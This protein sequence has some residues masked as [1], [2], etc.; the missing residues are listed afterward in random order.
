MSS[1]EKISVQAI[2]DIMRI[3]PSEELGRQL[4]HWWIKQESRVAFRRTIQPNNRPD[5]PETVYQ[6]VQMIWDNALRDARLELELNANSDRLVNAT[7]IA[8]EDEIYLAKAQLE[9]I[10]GSNQRLRVQLKDSQNSVKKMEAERAMLRSN[11]QSAEKT[12]S[13]MKNAVSEA[14]SEMQRAV[15]SSDEAK[16]QL[17]NR[18]KEETT[19]NNTNIGKLESKASYYRHQLDKLRDDW[20]KKEAGLNSQVQELQAVAAR[21]TVTQDTQFSQIR[22]QD[23]ELRKYRGEITNQSRHMS[24]SNSQA[25]ASTNRVKRLEDALQQREFDVKELQKRAMV[26][27]SDA[28]RREKELRK[29]IKSR[30]VEGLEINNNLLGLQRTLIAREEEIRRLTAKL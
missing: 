22:S 19:R 25:L 4:E 11:L 28:S 24:Q 15:S 1:G 30:E 5:I 20:G 2:A 7:G 16:K 9:A 10:E 17:D 18:M 14:K 6:T 26:E 27:K 21:G 13:S 8:L 12:I 3:K 29:L 23:E